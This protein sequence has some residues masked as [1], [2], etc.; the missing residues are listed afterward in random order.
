LF[1]VLIVGSLFSATQAVT[2][3][4]VNFVPVVPG[5]PDFRF[6]RLSTCPHPATC[7][8]AWTFARQAVSGIV[9]A[10]DQ[11]PAQIMK[12]PELK[13][14]IRR[15]PDLAVH[16]SMT[17]DERAA[18][19]MYTE[20]KGKFFQRI[21]CWLANPTVAKPPLIVEY[22]PLI[23]SAL[24][25]LKVHH[26]ETYRGTGMWHVPNMGDL[27]R[28]L[29]YLSTSQSGYTAL[30]FDGCNKYKQPG[31]EVELTWDTPKCWRII[32]LQGHS[33]K[34]LQGITALS[35]EAEVLMPRGS[36]FKVVDKFEIKPGVNYPKV[37]GYFATPA[38][39]QQFIDIHSK[40]WPGLMKKDDGTLDVR[41]LSKS[42]AGIVTLKSW[43]CKAND[44]VLPILE[45][46]INDK[47]ETIE[48]L[49]EDMTLDL[50]KDLEE[51]ETALEE[52]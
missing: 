22:I 36:C 51:F 12:S 23:T 5:E 3:N 28:N 39:K 19:F 9:A 25:K 43:S 48:D 35:G 24:S 49:S 46:N 34:S 7:W 32:F 13:G 38:Q 45:L 37:D 44:N 11:T 20:E 41:D 29:G 14:T 4:C 31:S 33:G 17:I 52:M 26:K 40:K 47:M 8:P 30:K 6:K 2:A 15:L 21:N 10:N 16:K 1:L 50:T 27:V 42:T 18:V